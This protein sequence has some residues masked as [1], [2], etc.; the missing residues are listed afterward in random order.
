MNG[1]EQTKSEALFLEYCKLRGYAANRIPDPCDAGRFADYEVRIANH[2]V[3]AEIKELQ[4]NPD[5]EQ[6]G[7]ALK[8]GRPGTFGDVPGRRVRKHIEDAEGQFQRYEGDQMSCMLV[9]YDNILV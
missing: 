7:K 2:R 1:A 5:D 6:L 3:I 8:E 4:A 9:L